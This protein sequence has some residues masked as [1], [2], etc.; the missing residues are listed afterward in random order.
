MFLKGRQVMERVDVVK[1]AGVNE[2]HEQ[3]P[4]VSPVLGLEEETS[5]PM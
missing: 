5:L 1:R 4:D 2:A 3:V